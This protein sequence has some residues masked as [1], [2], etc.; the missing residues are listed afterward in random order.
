MEEFAQCGADP[1]THTIMAPLERGGIYLEYRSH[2]GKKGECKLDNG[3]LDKIGARKLLVTGC[4]Y[5][6]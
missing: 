4:I 3:G 5:E 6:G 1:T 2:L